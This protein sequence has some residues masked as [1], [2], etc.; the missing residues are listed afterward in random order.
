MGFTRETIWALSDRG[1]IESVVDYKVNSR[2]GRDAIRLVAEQLGLRERLPTTPKGHR[3]VCACHAR[4][5]R[6]VGLGRPGAATHGHA[7]TT[8]PATLQ[9]SWRPAR[10]E[11]A[12]KLVRSRVV[13]RLHTEGVC[14]PES[15]SK[16]TAAFLVQSVSMRLGW[17]RFLPSII[18]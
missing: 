4:D 15:I 17:R 6:R 9:T 16:T 1:V 7:L 8:A 2:E 11:P 3:I 14:I 12:T 5:F 13:R 18:R 10:Q